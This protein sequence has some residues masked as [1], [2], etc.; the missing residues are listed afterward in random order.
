MKNFIIKKSL[1][2]ILCLVLIAAI[3][4]FAMGCGDSGKTDEVSST[5]QST[6][7]TELG[8]G[9]KSFVF[10]VTYADKSV[11]RFKV[12]TD[13]DTVGDALKEVELIDG[14]D[15]DYG[16]M[17][18]A[19]NNVTAKYEVDGKYWAFYVDGDY[20][21]AGVDKTPISDGSLYEFIVE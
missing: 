3:A 5:P 14:V 11:D 15:G 9:S 10:A 2:R 8:S 20:A 19:V 13:K 4:L 12:F 7:V 18:T 1:S 16:L 17:V 6:E 21:M